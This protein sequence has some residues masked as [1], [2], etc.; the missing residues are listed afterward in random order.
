MNSE[1]ARNFAFRRMQP[2]RGQKGIAGSLKVQMIRVKLESKI[3]PRK[4]DRRL[5]P[6]A[7]ARAELE[8][9]QTQAARVSNP[10]LHSFG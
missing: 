1:P 6:K 4:P 10:A 2:V 3:Y 7:G 8:P 5:I 9:V